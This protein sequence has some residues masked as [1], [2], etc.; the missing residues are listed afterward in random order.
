MSERG[1]LRIG[2]LGCGRIGR[3]HA[4]LLARRVPDASLAVVYDAVESLATEVAGSLGARVGSS[5][6]DVMYDADI[7]AVAI[8]S[9]TDT[10]VDLL[11]RAAEAGKPIFCEKPI[12]LDLGE[13]TR[14]LDAV[15][16]AGVPLQI[17][18]NRRFDPGHRAVRD[19]VA[20]GELGSLHLVR[21]SSRDPAPPPLEYIAVS[22]GIFLDMTGHD[23][24]MARFV[25]G[26]DA[27]EVYAQGSVWL[28]PASGGLW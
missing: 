1:D 2:V 12:S 17:G 16:A 23:F 7:D 10:H 5:V 25:T 19:A 18:F 28:R 24:D 13:V 8:S 26:S 3:M 27:V 22:G 4:E 11:V 15:S 9:S 6:D 14:A 20:T 21:I